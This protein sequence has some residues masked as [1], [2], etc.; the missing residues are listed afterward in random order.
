MIQAPE[1]EGSWPIVSAHLA[2]GV[3]LEVVVVGGDVNQ[4]F[5]LDVSDGADVVARRQH[6]LLVQRPLRLVVQAGGGV[7][8][9]HLVVLHRQIVARPLK[10]RHLSPCNQSHASRHGLPEHGLLYDTR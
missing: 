6:K 3:V 9:H 8:V 5:A 10:M 2:R 1:S 7:Q 4:P